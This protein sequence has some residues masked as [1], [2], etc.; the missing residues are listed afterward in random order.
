MLLRD[1]SLGNTFTLCEDIP[2]DV[3]TQLKE[4]GV[5]LKGIDVVEDAVRIISQ[6]DVIP[7]EIG[8]VGPIFA[9]EYDELKEKGYAMN[10]SVGKDGIEKAMEDT[11]KGK[12]GTKT[13]TVTNGSVVSSNI[14]EEPKGGNTVKLTINSDYQRDVQE[15]LENFTAYLRSSSNEYK[16]VKC[17]SIVVLDVKDNAVLAMATAPTFDLND[18]KSKYDELSDDEDN[19]LFNRATCGLYRPGS[20]FKT[21]TAT[22]GL[23]EGI[24]TG[25]ST[26]NCAQRMTFYDRS[27]AM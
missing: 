24:V 15:I 2:V 12:D 7:H 9:E 18:Y 23:N 6:G 10:D 27:R 19:P 17:G 22:A 20:T 25:Y 5:K 1:F 26:F 11:L 13:I 14:T 8:T 4:L 21:I 16:D 3:V